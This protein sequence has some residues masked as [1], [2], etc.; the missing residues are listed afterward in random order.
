MSSPVSALYVHSAISGAAL[1]TVTSLAGAALQALKDSISPDMG[2]GAFDRI[3]NE[4]MAQ[5]GSYNIV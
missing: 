2:A 1:S 4:R 5:Y 3:M